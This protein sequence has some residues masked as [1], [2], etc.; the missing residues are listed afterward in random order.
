MIKLQNT[1]A[2]LA[3]FCLLTSASPASYA[4]KT[5]IVVLENGDAVTGEVKSLDFGELRYST[6]SMGTVSIEWEEV[7]S[8]TSD[9][10]LQIEVTTGTRYFGNLVPASGDGKIAVARDINVQ[11]LDMMDIVR[12]TPIETDEKIWQRMEGSVSFGFDTD[13][14]SDVTS[15]YLNA[16]VRYRTR[17]YLLGVDVSNSVTN[18]SQ[19]P[20]TENR[21]IGLSYQRFR[22]N[23]WYVDWFGS[24]EKNDAQGIDQRLSAG[25]GLGKYVVQNNT[26]QLSI[27]A[28][29]VGTRESFVGPEPNTTNLEGK[30]EVKYLLRRLDPSSHVSLSSNYYPR[31]D[32]LSSFRSDSNLTLRREFID[33][34]FLDLSVYYRYLSDPPEGSVKEDYGV[35]TS[36]GYSF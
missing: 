1:R 2:I 23:R 26:N 29:L 19:A 25:V 31:L 22:P 7:L 32:D 6:D 35:T 15:S 4:A 33:D 28:G 11:E 34:L 24:T 8:L 16:S 10:D 5:D 3:A 27:L 14:A 13:K 30:I 9:Q 21:V 18:Q 12:I 36:L 17:R 20:T